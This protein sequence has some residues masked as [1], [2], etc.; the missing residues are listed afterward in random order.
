MKAGPEAIKAVRG[1][2]RRGQI[3]EAAT[4]LLG[5]Q[6]FHQMSV[7]DLAREAN[8]SVGTIYQYVKSKEDI[9]VLVM[10]D[11]MEGYREQV[12]RAMDGIADPLERLSSGFTAYCEVV[13]SHITATAIGYRESRTLGK[14]SL[15]KMMHLEEETTGLLVDC[16]NDCVSA[17]ILYPHDTETVGWDLSMLAHMWSLKHWHFAS[18]MPVA[19]YARVQ[20]ATVIAGLIRD[21]AASRY[22]ELVHP[23]HRAG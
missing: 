16:L 20:F 11:I 8:I 15:A 4:R 22:E 23:L 13:D 3:L 10:S 2:W 1:E 7:S 17:G 21:D 19:D 18:R 9:L 5:Q 12:P 14:E 6:G